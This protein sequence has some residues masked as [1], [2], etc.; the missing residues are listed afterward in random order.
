MVT[1]TYIKLSYNY[2]NCLQ[3]KYAY[4]TQSFIL[5]MIVES[6]LVVRNDTES[7]ISALPGFLQWYNQR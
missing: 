2:I 3:K 4:K 5:K 7:W 6:Q 1:S